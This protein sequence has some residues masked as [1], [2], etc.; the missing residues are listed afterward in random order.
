[1]VISVYVK[2]TQSNAARYSSYMKLL[3]FCMPLLVLN[4]WNLVLPVLRMWVL[5]LSQADDLFLIHV[6]SCRFSLDTRGFSLDRFGPTF[7]ILCV[8][9]ESS[10]SG[11][12]GRH[13]FA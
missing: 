5:C 4:P 11:P 6:G 13:C 12:S 7:N 2:S 1:M 3:T 9:H 10:C 8:L